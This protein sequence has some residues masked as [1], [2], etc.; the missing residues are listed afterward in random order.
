MRAFEMQQRLKAGEDALELSIEKWQD[1]ANGT[2]PDLAIANCA[3]CSVYYET[4]RRGCQHCGK[5]P[6]SLVTHKLYCENSP[7]ANYDRFWKSDEENLKWAKAEVEFLKSLRKPKRVRE[8][9]N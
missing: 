8:G 2:G 9:V 4:T 6:V 5:C 1:I 7:Y 3:L